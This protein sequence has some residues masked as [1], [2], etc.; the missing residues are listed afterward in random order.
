[1]SGILSCKGCQR[2]FCQ[3]HMSEHRQELEDDFQGVLSDRDSLYQ[4]IYSETSSTDPQAFDSITKWERKTIEKINMIADQARRQV[5]DL[6]DEKR[7]K[8]KEKYDQLSAELRQRKESSHFFEQDI[9][10]LSKTLEQV[11]HDYEH[12][13]TTAIVTVEAQTIDFDN[14]LRIT[15]NAKTN[16]H[17]NQLFLGGTL[18]ADK[19]HQSKLNEFYGKPHQQWELIYKATR[20]GFLASNFHRQCD[21]KAKTMVVIQSKNGGYLFG[22]YTAAPGVQIKAFKQTKQHLFSL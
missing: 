17:Q 13:D 1:M 20:D 12:K 7:L 11:K 3:G 6:L 18:L 16:V 15:P 14:I 2:N 4:Q 9:K 19:Q 5:Q 22:G 8:V 21:G 10:R